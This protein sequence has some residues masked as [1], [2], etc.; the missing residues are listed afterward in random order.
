VDQSTQRAAL[1]VL[2]DDVG[3]P[4][5]LADLID[6]ANTR[7]IQRRGGAGLLE[8]APAGRRVGLQVFARNLHRDGALDLGVPGAV[9]DAHPARAELS[10][11][12]VVAEPV[13]DHGG[14]D[15]IRGTTTRISL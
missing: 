11:N 15:S 5:G 14:N 13:A 8:Q 1:D 3:E 6:R 2:H 7:M 12:A 10:V 4:L 9:D